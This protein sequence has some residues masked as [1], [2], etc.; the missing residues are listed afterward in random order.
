MPAF[1]RAARTSSSTTGPSFVG[2]SVGSTAGP[3]CQPPATAR[4]SPEASKTRPVTWL[5]SVLASQVTIG[6]IQRG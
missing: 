6:A 3:R 5:D 1:L 2:S 4:V